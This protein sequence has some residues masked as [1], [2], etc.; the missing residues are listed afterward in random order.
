MILRGLVFFM[1]LKIC[2]YRQGRFFRLLSFFAILL[3]VIS[4]F[5]ITEAIF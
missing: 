5:K 3:N 2:Q 4:K 1:A